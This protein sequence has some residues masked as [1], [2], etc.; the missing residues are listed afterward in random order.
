LVN[1]YSLNAVQRGVS[2]CRNFTWG[3]VDWIEEEIMSYQEYSASEIRKMLQ[4]LFPHRKL[5]LSQFTFFNQIG[6]ARPTGVTSRRGRQCYKLED[7]LSIACVIALKE[8]GISLKNISELPQLIQQNSKKIFEQGSGCRLSGCGDKLSLI[9]AG[10]TIKNFALETFFD[11]SEVRMFW[12][13]DVG[14]LSEKLAIIFASQTA[15]RRAA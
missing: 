2:F 9:F 5:V 6:V 10:E 7:V 4:Q 14:A 15:I 8:E 3:C 1:Y 12:S 13:F 11:S